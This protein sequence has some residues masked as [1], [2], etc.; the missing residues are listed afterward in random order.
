MATQTEEDAP[1]ENKVPLGYGFSAPGSL[2][3]GQCS[4]GSDLY[5]D[6]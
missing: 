5:N 2:V 6:K 1:A 4:L 3:S